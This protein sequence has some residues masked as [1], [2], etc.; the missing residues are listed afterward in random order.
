MGELATRQTTAPGP[1]REA[2][3]LAHEMGG[4]L[5]AM[6]EDIRMAYNVEPSEALTKALEYLKPNELQ[7]WRYD[8]GFAPTGSWWELEKLA[9]ANPAAF[10]AQWERMR[11]AA[12]DD[13]QSGHLAARIVEGTPGLNS[14]QERAQF[15]MLREALMVDWQPKAGVEQ[16]LIDNIA[17]A[18]TL[19]QRCILQ[20]ATLEGNE[21]KRQRAE[22][23]K[24]GYWQPP[25]VTDFE[26]MQQEAEMAD[27]FNRLVVR[28]LRHLCDLRRY[29]PTVT[30]QAAGQVNIAQQQINLSPGPPEEP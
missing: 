5:H 25:R 22:Y 7:A 19:Y 2:N 20:L 18:Q 12:R 23:D 4:A 27:R 10:E 9:H 14:P 8:N 29:V 1:A 21:T 24:D 30:I 15:L 26:A 6:I 28:N 16:M 11:Q 17:Q 3:A 13:L